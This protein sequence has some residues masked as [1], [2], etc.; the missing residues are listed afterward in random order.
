M[1]VPVSKRPLLFMVDGS[2]YIFRAYH[3]LPPLTNKKGIPTNAVYGYTNMLIKVIE[4]YKPD[5]FIVV[6]DSKG[7][8]FRDGISVEYKANRGA[9]PDDLSVQFPYIFEINDVLGV[10]Q[11]S[12]EG[13]EA[14]DIIATLADRAVDKNFGVIIISS[15]KD[16]MSVI[17][18]NVVMLDTMRDQWISESYVVDKFGVKPSQI[19]EFLMLTGD[20]VDNIKGV[21]GIGKK[22]AAELLSKYTNIDGIYEHINDISSNRIKQSLINEKE[23]L[24]KITRQLIELKHDV[25]VEID[26][27]TVTLPKPFLPPSRQEKREMLIKTFTELEFT[28]LMDKIGKADINFDYKEIPSF[29]VV[30]EAA[31][32]QKWITLYIL[33]KEIGSFIDQPYY[34]KDSSAE[35]LK[36]ILGLDIK[37]IVH[38]AKAVY[39]WAVEHDIDVKAKLFGVELASYLCNPEMKRYTIDALA[40]SEL[41]EELPVISEDELAE[42]GD[43]YKTVKDNAIY[44]AKSAMILAKL[45]NIYSEKL[46]KDAIE[47]LFSNIEMPLSKILAKMEYTGIAV[48]RGY[49]NELS[50]V[51][52]QKINTL[53]KEMKSYVT[54]DFNPDSPKQ[55]AGVLFNELKLAHLK[56]TKNGYSTDN[57]VLLA[58]KD[59]HPFVAF[60]LEYRNIAKLK[61]GFIDS[62]SRFINQKTN[63]IHTHFIQTGTATGRLASIEPN[64]QNIPVKDENGKLIRKAFIADKGCSILSADYSQIEL[65]VMAHLSS[66][67]SLINAF[68]HDRDIH[69]LTASKIF[70]VDMEHVTDMMRTRAKVINF[71]IMYGMSAYGLSKELNISSEESQ[72]FIDSYF[73]EY[74]GIRAYIEDI[75]NGVRQTGYVGT[76]LGRRRYIP[77]TL[78]NPAYQRIAINTPVQGSAADLIKI[79]MLRVDNAIKKHGYDAK[80]LLQIH[81]ELIFEVKNE[82]IDAFSKVVKHE[83]E[84]AFKLH[85]PL[86]VSISSGKNWGE[87]LG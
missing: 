25:P 29:D 14:D 80:M 81:D 84:Y 62:L 33:G 51:Y 13:Y 82:E 48:D 38:D 70:H 63:R 56:K 87:T 7:P 26:F 37:I 68:L 17:S 16:I 6:F 83:M 59:K 11:V 47:P 61:N 79:S 32:E 86:K 31:I 49:L 40:I 73:N 22:T 8:T 3:A 1:N 39:R 35:Q 28:R 69:S 55:V 65:R 45:Y 67:E 4:K 85:V 12:K 57:E 52:S 78:D 9:P 66:D 74:K 46:S 5:Y 54:S 76:I 19:S 71:G 2:S 34:I 41:G 36:D 27:N 53:I 24:Y 64:L 58:L 43:M 75:L 72:I 15:D 18:D 10:S 50:S 77:K 21:S 20:A 60:L 30:K 23:V 42:Q 44:V